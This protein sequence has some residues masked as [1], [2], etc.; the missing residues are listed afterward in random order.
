MITNSEIYA[1]FSKTNQVILFDLKTNIE[2]IDSLMEVYKKWEQEDYG[3]KI[4]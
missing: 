4:E 3:K 2:E 1:E